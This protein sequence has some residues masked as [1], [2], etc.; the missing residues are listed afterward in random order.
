MENNRSNQQAP[1]PPPGY[2]TAAAEQGQAGGKKG[3]RASTKSRGE[4]GFIEGCL[5][6]LCCCWI[7]EMC[8]D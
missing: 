3:G 8:C 5:A 1:P 2:P 7:C 6:A 4:K